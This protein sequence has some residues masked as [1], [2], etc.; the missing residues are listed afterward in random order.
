MI[1]ATI[2]VDAGTIAVADAV[3]AGGSFTINL[4]RCSTRGPQDRLDGDQL[5]EPV[6]VSQQPAGDTASASSTSPGALLICTTPRSGSW[7][8][9]DLLERTGKIAMG[10]EYFHVN[11]VPALAREYGLGSLAITEEYISEIRRRAQEDGRLFSSKLHWVQI[12]QLVDALRVVHP[13]L[14]AAN[15]PAPELIE[16]SLPGSRYLFLTREDKARQA[17][18]LFRALRTDTWWEHAA[19]GEPEEQGQ[20]A[21]ELIAD[22]LAIRWLEDVLVEQEAEWR[23]YFEVFAIEP[24]TVVYEQLCAEPGRVV[25]AVLDWLGL[26]GAVASEGPSR[27]RRQADAETETM[28]VEYR[29][30]R[31]S[32]PPHPPSWA[33]SF[34]RRTFVL[35]KA[36]EPLTSRL[37][38]F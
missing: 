1:I 24:L 37:S 7:L 19:E 6:D 18:S 16:A 32:L 26:Q 25:R 3:P 4:H 33:W 28:L 8:L 11:Y 38:P 35:L 27:L 17:I 10:Q 22:Y 23:R 20:A 12:N 29:D 5:S 36:A 14:A 15:T 13:D 21:P 9:S 2:E 34:E 31:G 30:I